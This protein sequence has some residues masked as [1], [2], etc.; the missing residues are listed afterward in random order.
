MI[1]H[2]IYFRRETRNILNG[3]HVL[4]GLMINGHDPNQTALICSWARPLLS[5]LGIWAFF[6]HCPPYYLY[7]GTSINMTLIKQH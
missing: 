3:Y 6:L 7:S 1:T 4:S 2:N 5:T